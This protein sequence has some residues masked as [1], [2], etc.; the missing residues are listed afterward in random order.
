MSFEININAE[1][2]QM[3]MNI[4][5]RLDTV[6]A[7]EL[8]KAFAAAL[9]E[10]E[11][12]DEVLMD[13]KDL[14]YISSSGLRFLLG[15]YKKMIK[16]GGNF[17]V[18]RPTEAV[19]EVFETTGFDRTIP[20][21][22]Q[23]PHS[24]DKVDHRLYP[25]RPI[26]RFMMDVH[27]N[28]AGSTMMNMVSLVRLDPSINM[29][30]LKDALNAVLHSHDIFRC[31]FVVDDETG[32]IMQRFDGETEDV[33]VEEMTEEELEECLRTLSRP[34]KVI[35]NPLWNLRLLKAGSRQYFYADFYHV[36]MDGVAAALLF[37][38]EMEKNYKA[39]VSGKS[40]A[41]LKRSGSSYAAYIREEMADTGYDMEEGVG[42]W[43]KMLDGFSVK[44]N[45]PAVDSTEESG[46]EEVEFPIDGIRRDFF[47]GAPYSEPGFFMGATLLALA[48]LTGKKTA[49]MSWVHN[50]RTNSKELRL[51]G[52]MLEQ[53]PIRW[54]FDKDMSVEDY[55]AALDGLMKEGM[56]YRKSLGTIYSE[57]LDSEIACFIFQKGAIGRRGEL[58]L[59]D[60]KA[61]IEPLPDGEES[62][63]ESAMD[64]ELNAHE[65]GSFSVVFDYDTG[66]YSPQAIE[67]CAD[68]IRAVI[69]KMQ[70]GCSLLTILDD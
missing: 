37:W 45:L 27:F 41:D 14:S 58:A 28:K 3:L 48:K 52:I 65:D 5:G 34:Y 70:Q 19:M 55:L 18:F 57:Y 53:L 13:L 39:L 1:E 35:D 12:V 51:M 59:G 20:M 31:R 44:E 54:D 2:R 22:D 33:A 4:S 9:S 69:A 68:V 40:A 11:D 38:R 23:E 17:M 49:I 67:N 61:V 24:L 64:I 10:N 60:T 36:I 46:D 66:M 50:G 63:A 56:K 43:R 15:S 29:N 47:T 25:L 62:A 6:A 42:Y 32:E 30:L 26:Q 16:K 7:M 8:E 21:E